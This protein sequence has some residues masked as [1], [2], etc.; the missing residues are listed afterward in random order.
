MFSAEL[1][2]AAPYWATS[3]PTE[4]R[5]ILMSYTAPYWAGEPLWATPHPTAVLYL[6][7][8]YP[9]ELGLTYWATPHP[10]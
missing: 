5:R 1:S 8:P 2:Y 4:L 6:A 10:K 3:Q 7:A 9:N